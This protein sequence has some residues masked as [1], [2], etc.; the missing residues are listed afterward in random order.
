[1]Y[2]WEYHAHCTAI[3]DSLDEAIATLVWDSD[4]RGD[5]CEQPSNR[6]LTYI[7]NGQRGVL[8]IDEK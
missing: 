2:M 6:Q 7:V 1:M 5:A 4:K 8:Q 3:Q